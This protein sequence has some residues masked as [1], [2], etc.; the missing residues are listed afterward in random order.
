MTTIIICQDVEKCLPIYQSALWSMICSIQWKLIYLKRN[1]LP[2]NACIY[3]A[4]Y[5]KNVLHYLLVPATSPRSTANRNFFSAKFNAWI[6][7]CGRMTFSSSI[8]PWILWRCNPI[9]KRKP[10]ELE[11]SVEKICKANWMWDTSL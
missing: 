2:S 4:I 5:V 8:I 7:W 11:M 3:D 9:R 1:S 6:S 10:S